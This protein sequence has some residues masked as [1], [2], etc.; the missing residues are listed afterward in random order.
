MLEEGNRTGRG[1]WV[2]LMVAER[3]WRSQRAECTIT[4]TAMRRESV[5]ASE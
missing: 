5:V 1:E 3:R 4:A 2:W